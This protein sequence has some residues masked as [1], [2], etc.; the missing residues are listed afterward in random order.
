M[1]C[2][3][4]LLLAIRCLFAYV[5]CLYLELQKRK[6]YFV[7]LFSMALLGEAKMPICVAQINLDV[8]SWDSGVV[9]TGFLMIAIASMVAT[10]LSFR[11]WF[12]S[13]MVIC[14]RAVYLKVRSFYRRRCRWSLD[15]YWNDEHMMTTLKQKLNVF[16]TQNVRTHPCQLLITHNNKSQVLYLIHIVNSKPI[17]SCNNVV[18]QL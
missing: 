7:N 14:L 10:T 4:K 1:S 6:H 2:Y 17:V 9:S 3:I 15:K 13:T 8:L 5:I 16:I 11:Q 18:H 12:T